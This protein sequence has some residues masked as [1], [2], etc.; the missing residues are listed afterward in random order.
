MDYSAI[1][2]AVFRLFFI[3]DDSMIDPIFKLGGFK[4]LST[5]QVIGVDTF[6]FA[7]GPI[8]FF[9]ST[10]GFSICI[11]NLFI[12][13]HSEAYDAAQENAEV[14]FLKER[15]TLCLQCLLR[16]YVHIEWLN[17]GQSRL[18]CSLGIFFASVLIW[19]ALLEA[20]QLSVLLPSVLLVSGVLAADMVLLQRPWRDHSGCA[21]RP[22]RL[23][24]DGQPR[25]NY[26]WYV[27][28]TDFSEETVL[29]EAHAQS[30]SGFRG[31]LFSLK[32]ESNSRAKEVL[33]DIRSLK[34]YFQE[35]GLGLHRVSE[36]L[37][38]EVALVRL[39]LEDSRGSY[40]RDTWLSGTLER[41]RSRQPTAFTSNSYDHF[42][43]SQSKRTIS[44]AETPTERALLHDAEA[45]AQ[46][47]ALYSPFLRL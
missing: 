42:Q 15:A 24:R 47:A 4:S 43:V 17:F 44:A 11:L 35:V 34:L 37:A 26:L 18:Q 16:P 21:E 41:V 40:S 20:R 6:S 46:P 36:R 14:Q 19:V 30:A 5:L 25:H 27:H 23:C 39:R 33:D 9:M 2:N 32:S 1:F 31:R 22:C 38:R 29:T 3:G 8:L 45:V 12:A 13:V 10:I 28:R 7:P